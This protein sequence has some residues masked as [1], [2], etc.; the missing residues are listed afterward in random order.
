MFPFNGPFLHLTEQFRGSWRGQTV[1]KIA[2]GRPHSKEHF[3]GMLGRLA[4]MDSAGFAGFGD[5]LRSATILSDPR[6]KKSQASQR[7]QPTYT[8]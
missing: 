8:S 6:S 4:T 1:G 3:C 2:A 5:A 7:A